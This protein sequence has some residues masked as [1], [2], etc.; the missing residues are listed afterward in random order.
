MTRIEVV[1]PGFMTTVQDRGRPGFAHLGVPPSGAA[2]ANALE[3]GNHLVGNAP[4]AAA[5]EATLNGPALRFDGP[6]TVAL[7]GAETRAP[8]GVCVFVER[9]DV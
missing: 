3:V 8:R 6:A 9:G 7:T 5:L 4:S 1:R 2:D